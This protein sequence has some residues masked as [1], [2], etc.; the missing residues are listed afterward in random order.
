M[1]ILELDF[2]Q[3]V[4]L[5]LFRLINSEWA[6]RYFDVLFPVITDLHKTPLFK[7][8]FIPFIIFLFLY[9]RRLYGL[10]VLVCMLLTLG[11]SDWLGGRLKHTVM[12]PRPFETTVEIVQRSGAG[13]YSFPS[14]HALN[15]F[16]AAMFLGCFFPRYR[17]AFFVF[18]FLV[19]ISRV[20][21]GVHYP[22]DIFFGGLLG[23]LI[24]YVGARLTKKLIRNLE[25][26]KKQ[27]V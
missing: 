7:I 8:I 12:R 22:S 15:I 25:L 14:N 13:G 3:R 5:F 24:G 2:F 20:Y 26:R 18:A 19:A 1:N 27:N 17:I 4:D 6:H 10:L 23:I 9:W 21:N 11:F 16:C